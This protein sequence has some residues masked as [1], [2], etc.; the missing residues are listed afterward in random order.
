MQVDASRRKWVAK[1]NASWTQ[2]QNLHQRAS[3]FGQ[4][5]KDKRASFCI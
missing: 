2:V 1:Q 5:L 3:L 4:G